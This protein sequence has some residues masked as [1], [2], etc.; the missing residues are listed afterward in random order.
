MSS[1]KPLHELVAD[2]VR[3]SPGSPLPPSKI[4]V[5]L[6]EAFPERFTTKLAGFGGDKGSLADQVTREIYA[7]WR[8][9][10]EKHPD[11]AVDKSKSP[12]VFL[13]TP[14][15]GAKAEASVETEERDEPEFAADEADELSEFDLYPAI[16]DF[17]VHLAGNADS[18]FFAM[19]S[20]R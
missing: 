14:G 12:M 20:R 6:I 1:H 18:V 2:Y 11:V 10:T 15:N 16:R 19:Q 9:I 17:L 7:Q 3:R 4:A 8:L 5:G 13:T